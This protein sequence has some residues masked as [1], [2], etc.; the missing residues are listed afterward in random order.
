MWLIDSKMYH[1]LQVYAGT[2]RDNPEFGKC[3]VSIERA[4]RNDFPKPRNVR[5]GTDQK[6]VMTLEYDDRERAEEAQKILYD[7]REVRSVCLTKFDGN[8]RGRC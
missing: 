2:S 3:V 4:M 6:L 8:G 1:K 7:L 5:Q